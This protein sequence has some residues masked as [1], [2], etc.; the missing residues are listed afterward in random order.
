M[1]CHIPDNAIRK[2]SSLIPR[3][4]A[5]DPGDTSG[6]WLKRANVIGLEVPCE[7]LERRVL[8]RPPNLMFPVSGQELTPYSRFARA[9]CRGVTGLVPQPLCMKLRL[10][11]WGKL[12][13]S[14]FITVEM[15]AQA[16]K[17]RTGPGGLSMVTWR[18]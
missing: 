4:Y 7:P 12:K 14:R 10:A 1:T 6:D 17:Q 18:G 8:K 5:S 13:C 3:M 9:G 2:Q 11:L 15:G 16:A